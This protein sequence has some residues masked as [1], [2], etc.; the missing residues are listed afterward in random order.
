MDADT[1]TDG[2]SACA[3]ADDA[4]ITRKCDP[5]SAGEHRVC[6]VDIWDDVGAIGVGDS[7]NSSG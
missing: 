4:D 2:D 1:R 5:S 6:Y 7:G 3:D